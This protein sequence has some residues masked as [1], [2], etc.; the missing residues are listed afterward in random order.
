MFVC[1]Y[2]VVYVVMT[3]VVHK[4][5]LPPEN[6]IKAEK[7]RNASKICTEFVYI[8]YVS[9]SMYIS[10]CIYLLYIKLALAF[11]F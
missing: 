11:A 8:H 3:S 2:I 5:H 4:W 9:I 7:R 10:M 6:A 1:M